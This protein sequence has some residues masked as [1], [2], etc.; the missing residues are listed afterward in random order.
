M[1]YLALTATMKRSNH[2]SHS[3]AGDSVG[4]DQN[5]GNPAKTTDNY[6]SGETMYLLAAPC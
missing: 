1:E 5:K 3:I 2:L 6:L 4:S